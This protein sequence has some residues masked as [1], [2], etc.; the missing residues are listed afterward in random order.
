MNTSAPT[1]QSTASRQTTCRQAA[2][3]LTLAALSLVGLTGCGSSDSAAPSAAATASVATITTVAGT[4]AP[5]Y[6]GDNQPATAAGLHF[7]AGVAVDTAGTLWIADTLTTRIRKVDAAGVITT[8]AGGTGNGY[9]GDGGLAT[10][11]QVNV[12]YGV[13]VD[14]AGNFWIADSQNHRIRK[15][16]AI[17]GVITTV[18][19]TGTAGYNG[20]NQPATAAQVNGP[21]GVA[22]DT[23]GNLWIADLSNHRIRKVGL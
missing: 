19:G 18:A 16:D 20:D 21:A 9:N 1:N 5:G 22:V 12:P 3:L 4:G 17:T 15:V 14:R 6:N 23:A 8:V 11:A 7:P 10:L 13:A 2:G